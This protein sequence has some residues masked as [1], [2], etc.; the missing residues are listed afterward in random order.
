MELGRHPGALE[1]GLL[2]SRLISPPSSVSQVYS[3]LSSYNT[4]EG[5]EIGV[6]ATVYDDQLDRTW[7]EERRT[8]A[9]SARVTL[10]GTVLQAE[11]EVVTP[12]GK[13]LKVAMHD[14]GLHNDEEP[15]DGVYGALIKAA[16]VGTYQAQA[17]IRGACRALS[18]AFSLSPSC[19]YVLR[20][21][22]QASPP[23]ACSTCA[24]RSSSCA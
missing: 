7:R 15:N 23:P 1:R 6:V 16:E 11:M 3:R 2:R 22:L 12:A 10:K 8:P 20:L 14:D 18:L 17:F 5:S 21:L 24:P 13:A 19:A 9:R 4:T